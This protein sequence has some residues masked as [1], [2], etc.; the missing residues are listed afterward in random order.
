M[1]QVQ[2]PIHNLEDLQWV[3]HLV[4][5]SHQHMDNNLQPMGNNPLLMVNSLPLMVNNHQPMVSHLLM[6]NQGTHLNSPA[7]HLSNLDM[8][9]H[10]AMDNNPVTHLSNLDMDNHLLTAN[11][12]Q[13]TVNLNL[14]IHHNSRDTHLNSQVTDSLNPAIL[15]NSQVTANLNPVTD[16]LNPV[17]AN[18]LS[19]VMANS[20]NQ[21]T[22]NSPSPPTE[23]LPKVARSTATAMQAIPCNGATQSHHLTKPKAWTKLSAM[24]A[25]RKLQLLTGTIIVSHAVPIFAKTAEVQG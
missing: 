8:D 3:D 11:H 5:D 16:N 1:L 14:A 2:Q 22:V 24:C 25:N 21:A 13:D 18:S 15:H 10:Q 7:I 12:N 4:M 17:T 6:D 20:L 23:V 9:N 19:Q